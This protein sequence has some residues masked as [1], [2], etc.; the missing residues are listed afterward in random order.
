VTH[1]RH[2]AD[3][4]DAEFHAGGFS[5]FLRSLLSGIPWSERA[6]ASEELHFDAPSGGAFRL[7]NPN[8]RTRIHGED[9][10]DV[11][12]EMIKVS[13]AESREAA[14]ELLDEIRLSPTDADDA[15]ELEVI[16][17]RKWNRRGHAN[18]TVHLPRELE[19]EVSAVNGRVSVEGVRGAVQARSSN[20]S[21]SVSD[22]V[23]D[24]KVMTSNAKVSCSC[25]CGKLVARSSN[26]KIEIDGH[27]G[28][29]DA[30]TSNG[31]IRAALQ[32]V[33]KQGVQLSTSNGR[34]VIELPEQVDADVD[35]R[36]DNGLIR[37]DRELC[38]VQR[39]TNGRVRGRLGAGG[40]LIKL[41]TS[42]GSICLR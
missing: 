5:G 1:R 19:V 32:R 3:F 10:D 20:G 25:I 37:N 9:R 40:P 41:R 18:L 35:V 4:E 28:S 31:L 39:E 21:A 34:I 11:R 26:G 14:Q 15:L 8:G 12:V 2:R 13:R 30:S 36:V 23:G 24:V 27:Q 16:A 29:V 42:N 6:E 17:P 38:E 22:I 7:H 33:G